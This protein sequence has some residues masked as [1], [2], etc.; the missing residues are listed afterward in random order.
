LLAIKQR[1]SIPGGS[2]DFDLPALRFWLNQD[3]VK[4]VVDLERWA[5]PYLELESVIELVLSVIRD[6]AMPEKVVAENG[7]F[8]QS[9]DS[10]QSNQLLR[11]SIPAGEEIY[12]EVSAGKHR[13]SVRFLNPLPIDDLPSQVKE[14][15]TFCLTRC[16]L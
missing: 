8:H 11:I 16:S 2:C 15:V 13:Y 12:P 6:S 3:Q 14:D 1:T 7:F 9:L 4:R 10:Q 5:E